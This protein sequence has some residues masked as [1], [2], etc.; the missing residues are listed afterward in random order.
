MLLYH[1]M[2]IERY[3]LKAESSFTVF[4]FISEGPKGL[5]RKLIQFQLTN[6]PNLYNLAFS[7]KIAETGEIDDLELSNNGDSEKVLATVVAALYA[8]CDKHPDAFVDATG[9]TSSRT[10][11]YRKGI[12]LLYKEIVKDFY[13][14]GQMG[15][16]FYEF[17]IGKDYIGFLTQRK[18]I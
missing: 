14:F 12:T 17:Q 16:K 1:N 5:I 9:S 18:F 8:F 13:L 6:K 4:E 3:P 2:K 15:N 11:L 10:R 7:E